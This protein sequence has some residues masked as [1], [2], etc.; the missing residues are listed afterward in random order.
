MVDWSKLPEDLLCMIAVRLF[1]A[2]EF[3]RFRSICRSWRSSSSSADKNPFPPRPVL[4]LNPLVVSVTSPYGNIDQIYGL[5]L[6]AFL[7]RAAF[8]RVTLSSSSERNQSWLIKSDADL[9]SGKFRLLNPLSRLPLLQSWKQSIDLLEF[10]V[11]EIRE[12]YLVQTSRKKKLAHGLNRVILVPVAGGDPRIVGI[13]ID[14]KIRYWNGVIWTRFKD[15]MAEFSDII[16]HKG[17]TYALDSEGGVWWVSS[18]L[19]IF[20]YGPS[21]DEDIVTSGCFSEKSLVECCGEL[22]IVDRILEGKFRKRKVDNYDDNGVYVVR[23]PQL[24]YAIHDD[25]GI[26]K[27]QVS[28][29]KRPNTVGFK[30]YKMSEESGKWVEVKSMGDNVIVMATDCCFSV[31]PHEFYGCLQ[32][33][34]YFSDD[35]EELKVFK[36]DDDSITT[37][38][39]T[40]ISQGC[41]QMF[42]PSFR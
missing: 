16:V 27:C 22:Y 14:G 32:S 2:V 17:L 33:S 3:Q 28:L 18:S 34:I 40:G 4:H 38:T 6:S 37:K 5:D 29:G 31:S 39:M 24:H 42:D 13:G 20:R 26:E 41:F 36:L 35:E 15:Q 30:V 19:C 11:S 10:T 23:F 9:G 25:A 12:A 7:S 8:F 1:S 21:L